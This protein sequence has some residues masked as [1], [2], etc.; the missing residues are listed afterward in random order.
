MSFPSRSFLSFC[1]VLAVL[2]STP[3]HA[4]AASRPN[5]LVILADD[6]GAG[7]LGC[8]GNPD[9]RTPALDRL[10]REGVRL[11]QHYSAAPLCSPARAALLTGRYPQRVGAISVESNRGLDRISLGEATLGD[12]FAAAGYQTGLIGKWHNGLYDRRYLPQ[13]R[14]FQDVLAFY[15]GGMGYHAWILERN[16]VPLRSDG[17]YLTDVFADEAVQFIER[18]RSEPWLLYLP[19]SAPHLPL[20][21]LEEDIAPYLAGGKLTPEVA[22]VYAMITRMDRGIG[23]ILETLARLGLEE[24]TLVLFTSDNGTEASG[25]ASARFNGPYRGRKQDV[26]EGGLRVPAI[27][28]WPAGLPRG[29]T[30]DHL[31]HATDW[32]PTLLSVAG[33][34]PGGGKPFDGID[35]LAALRGE[36]SGPPP[37]RFWHYNRYAPVARCNGAMRDGDWKLYFPRIEAAMKK[38]PSDNAPYHELYH[39]EHYQQPIDRTA[40]PRTVPP[41][42][43]PQL[44]NIRLDP[45]EKQNLAAQEPARVR[46]MSEQW[47]RWFATVEA[48]RRQLPEYAG[49]EL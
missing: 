32:L 21:A 20:E 10:A 1:A 40:V 33:V 30:S 42:A 47:D 22:T 45:G 12:H 14:G 23:R 26:L 28:R 16:G 13:A 7:D 24:N 44:Y 15:N 38:L 19:L 8:Y 36:P 9:L 48:E 25:A 49:H 46:A 35:Q 2:A 34:R 11:T 5:I 4:A 3:A 6:L 27:V 41:P 18:H 29:K 31:V 39:R 43:A 17:R 37:A